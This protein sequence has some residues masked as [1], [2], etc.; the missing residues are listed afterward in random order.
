MARLLHQLV[1]FRPTFYF[2]RMNT[3]LSVSNGI[4]QTGQASLTTKRPDPFDCPWLNSSSGIY[5]EEI[6]GSDGY[7]RYQSSTEDATRTTFDS[8]RSTQRIDGTGDTRYRGNRSLSGNGSH[9]HWY[10]RIPTGDGF[11][12]EQDSYHMELLPDDD[13]P[14]SY[15]VTVDHGDDASVDLPTEYNSPSNPAAN[16]PPAGSLGPGGFA[17][18]EDGTEIAD[19]KNQVASNGS[20]AASANAAR[21]AAFAELAEETESSG[22]PEDPGSQASEDSLSAAAGMATY[23]NGQGSLPIPGNPQVFPELPFGPAPSLNG[24]TFPNLRGNN[25]FTGFTANNQPVPNLHTPTQ[26]CLAA[27]P[28]PTNPEEAGLGVRDAASIGVGFIPFVGSAQSVVELISGHDYI[29]GEPTSRW[30]AA[31][32]IIA[33]VVPGGKGALKGGSKLTKIAGK[34]ATKAPIGAAALPWARAG[35]ARAAKAIEAGQT[36][37]KVASRDDAAELIWR[38]FRSQGYTDTTMFKSGSVVKQYLGSKAGTYHWDDVLDAAGNVAGHGAGNA[39]GTMR[40]VQIHLQET[41]KIIR[42]FFP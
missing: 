34:A 28:L 24:N 11:D 5:T 37:I 38:M 15:D 16:T 40:H 6:N 31:A 12:V 30:L 14:D 36:S 41:G 9:S 39:H 18:E 26:P 42:I 32:G 27:L 23:V 35:A 7:H 21:D 17:P 25:C 19:L 20:A 3:R 13:R 2:A 1:V 33:G 22:D 8:I 10:E 4:N 29:A